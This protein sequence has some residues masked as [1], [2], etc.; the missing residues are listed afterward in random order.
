MTHRA[1]KNAYFSVELLKGNRT[2]AAFL[3]AEG[4]GQAS[5]ES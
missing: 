5:L 3:K 4:A 2:Q 1:Y